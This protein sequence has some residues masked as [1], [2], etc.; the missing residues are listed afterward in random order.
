MAYDIEKHMLGNP[1]YKKMVEDK[2]NQIFSDTV[3]SDIYWNELIKR[4]KE[5]IEM[6]QDKP[7]EKYYVLNHFWK[8]FRPPLIGQ[9]EPKRK[10]NERGNGI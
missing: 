7:K 1:K 8:A 2:I 10:L 6:K 5:R 9:R 4:D 3:K